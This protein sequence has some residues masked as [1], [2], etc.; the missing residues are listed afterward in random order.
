MCVPP[1]KGDD[2]YF[3]E[4]KCLAK[5]FMEKVPTSSEVPHGHRIKGELQGKML[6]LLTI[7]NTQWQY[8]FGI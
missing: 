7:G 4:T 5:S 6:T 2:F 3:L 1:F 8:T